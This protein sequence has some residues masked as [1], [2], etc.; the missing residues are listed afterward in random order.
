MNFLGFFK[1]EPA[2]QQQGRPYSEILPEVMP[3]VRPALMLSTA[4][5]TTRSYLGGDPCLPDGLPWPSKNGTELVFLACLDLA[6]IAAT[7]AIDWLPAAGRLLF[8]IDT[9][10]APSGYDPDE[11]GRWAVLHVPPVDTGNTSG[12]ATLP[13]THV[14]FTRFD[15]LPDGQRFDELGID[16]I[17]EEVDRLVDGYLNRIAELGQHQVGGYPRPIQDDQMELD[18][19]LAANGIASA[20]NAAHE[21]EAGRRLAT[22]AKDWRL[23]LQLASDKELGVTW[24]DLGDLYFWI[25]EEDARNSNFGAVWIILQSS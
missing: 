22:G 3:H 19:Q 25:R 17:D 2:P 14:A 15:S 13:R 11:R 24:S 20:S 10:D 5:T 8:F 23:L 4:K 18:V 6:E 21:S 1:R 12:H 7:D 16:L 9:D